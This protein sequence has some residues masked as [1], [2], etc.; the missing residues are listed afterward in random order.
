MRRARSG[1]GGFTLIEI[2]AVVLIFALLA[3]I[4]LPNL[5]FRSA[6]VARDQARSLA[7][8]L[9]LARQQAL[10]TG[11]PTRMVLDLDQQRWWLEQ[12]RRAAEP[13]AKAAASADAE[14]GSDGMGGSGAKA[15]PSSVPPRY[16]DV[17]PLPLVAPPPAEGAFHAEAGLFGQATPLGH[18]TRIEDVQ[19]DTGAVTT[20]HAYIR[21]SPDGSAPRTE[22]A[23]RDRDGGTIH[24]EVAPLADG[25][26][27]HDAGP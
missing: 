18:D 3:A 9:E 8:T 21:F 13:D 4:A 25:I 24:L 16:A 15:G 22:L 23:L 14:D 6:Q 19:T 7:A 5:H 27:I 20:G 10:A 17:S 11:R 12:W 26:R 1:S 2:L